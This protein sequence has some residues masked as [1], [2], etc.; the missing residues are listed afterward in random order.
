[1]NQGS[2][3]FQSVLATEMTDFLGHQRALGKRFINEEHAL[4]LFDHYLVGEQLKTMADI[5]PAVVD[6]FLAS[7]PRSRPPSIMWGK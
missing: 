1:M 5:T 4:R 2:I 6:A 3:H 7:R